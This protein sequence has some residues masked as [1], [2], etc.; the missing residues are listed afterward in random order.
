MTLDQESNEYNAQHINQGPPRQRTYL[1]QAG[2]KLIGRT[3]KLVSAIELGRTVSTPIIW[4][5]LEAVLGVDQRELRKIDCS[6][7]VKSNAD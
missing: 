1:E 4:D 6:S 7:G 3:G 2:Q 5:K